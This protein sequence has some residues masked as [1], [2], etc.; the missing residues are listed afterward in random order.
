MNKSVINAAYR[1]L[2]GARNTT[3]SQLAANLCQ[4]TLCVVL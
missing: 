1:G 4:L 3:Q 2:T